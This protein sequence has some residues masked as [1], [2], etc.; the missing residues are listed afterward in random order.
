[1]NFKNILKN[2]PWSCKFLCRRSMA[3]KAFRRLSSSKSPQMTRLDS[4]KSKKM[5]HRTLVIKILI[6]CFLPTPIISARKRKR[7]TYFFT[8]QT[9]SP[10]IEIKKGQIIRKQKNLNELW[11][12]KCSLRGP[13][14]PAKELLQFSSAQQQQIWVVENKLSM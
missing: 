12:A 4:W 8:T 9:F 3:S 1:M 7:K 11:V 13:S 14:F 10:W 6:E 5:T 2:L